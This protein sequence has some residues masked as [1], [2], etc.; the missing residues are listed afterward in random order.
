MLKL[1]FNY[2]TLIAKKILFAKR[3]GNRKFMIELN[4]VVKI[5]GD[6][7]SA[8]CALN[9]ISLKIPDKKLIAIIGKSGCGKSTMLNLI[10]GLDNITKGSISNNGI[11]LDSLSDDELADYRN[12]NIGFIFQSFYLE[13]TFTVLENV[14]MPLVIAGMDKKHR[15]EKAFEIINKLGLNDKL[16]KKVKTLS[17]GQKQRV[18]IARALVHSPDIIL[19]DEPTGNLDSQNGAEVISI[20]KKISMEGKTVILV[21]HNMEDAL[22]ADYIVKLCD[23]KIEKIDKKDDC[24]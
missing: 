10:G 19:A 12:K 7:E 14:E 8:V 13:P 16:N 17:G 18:A 1:T 5:Y 3:K 4:N 20:L 11:Y 23:G 24:R 15:R 2:L 6:G 9:D 21:T 22:K